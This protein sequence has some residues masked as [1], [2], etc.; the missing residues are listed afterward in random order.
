M[1]RL[2]TIVGLIS[3]LVLLSQSGYAADR[4]YQGKVVDADTKEPIEGAVVIAVWRETKGT[5]TGPS[6]KFKESKETL[7]DKHGDWS[8]AGPEGCEDNLIPGLLHSMGFFVTKHPE[9]SLYKPGYNIRGFPG[10]FEAY[11]YVDRKHDLE[12][13]VL[14]RPG[15]T[16]EEIRKFGEK[17]RG[18][19]P[20]I[21]VKD[22]EQ[23][24]RNLDFSFQYTKE[25]KIV[26]WQQGIGP[27]RVFTVTG[28]KKATTRE[29]RLK[30]MGTL[31]VEGSLP[32]Y[33]R[34][35]KEE[36]KNLGLE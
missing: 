14:K 19:L 23:K 1:K 8:I 28:L 12:G 30:A 4:I 20:F 7:T 25:F 16:S 6:S 11:P 31:L 9:F 17:Y 21:A 34:L 2:K 36:R 5:L 24:L 29:E 32:I 26:G 33:G 3:T 15:D 13:I 27:Y 10:W 18:N 35:I 22:P